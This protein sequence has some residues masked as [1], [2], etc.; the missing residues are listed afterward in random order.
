MTAA[1]LPSTLAAVLLTLTVNACSSSHSGA[2]VGSAPNAP[3]A[4]SSSAAA[5]ITIKN[6]LFAPATITVHPGEQVT[7]VNED[8]TTHTVTAEDKSFDTGA[9][10]G[11]ASATFTAPTTPGSYPYICTIHQYMHATLTV[12]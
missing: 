9:V 3:P 7:V 12:S 5:R 1:R 6:F 2:P 4:G 8:A 11:G 10:N